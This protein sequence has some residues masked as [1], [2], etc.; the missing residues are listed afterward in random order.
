LS[1]LDDDWLGR[2]GYRRCTGYAE[3]SVAAWTLAP[4]AENTV[5]I[6][7]GFR[8]VYGSAQGPAPRR[9]P[10]PLDQSRP[11]ASRTFAAICSAV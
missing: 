6:R 1:R 5:L 8:R 9:W 7:E 2:G 3:L 10:G 4:K 11:M